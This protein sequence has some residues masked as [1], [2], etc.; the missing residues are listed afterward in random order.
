MLRTLS[1]LGNKASMEAKYIDVA[2]EKGSKEVFPRYLTWV[3][4]GK[5]ASQK[6]WF[7]DVL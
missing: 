4:Y 3:K 1:R 6:R 2:A 7:V 5:T